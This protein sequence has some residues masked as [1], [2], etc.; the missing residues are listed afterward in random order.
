MTHG[1]EISLGAAPVSVADKRE[2]HFGFMA[3]LRRLGAQPLANTIILL[4]E[5]PELRFHL[6]HGGQEASKA[7]GGHPRDFPEVRHWQH[8]WK[9]RALSPSKNQSEL[10]ESR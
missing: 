3:D 4:W 7:G 8:P 10:L 1:C 5:P 6:P 9:V 2:H